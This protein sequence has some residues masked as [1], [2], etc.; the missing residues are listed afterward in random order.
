MERILCG[1]VGQGRL[2]SYNWNRREKKEKKRKRTRDEEEEKGEE[3]SVIHNI[4]VHNIIIRESN[5]LHLQACVHTF[6]VG[7]AILRPHNIPL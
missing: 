2:I 3:S 7:K 1:G 6:R 4:S 5:Y